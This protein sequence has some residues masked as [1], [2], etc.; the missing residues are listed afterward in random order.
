MLFGFVLLFGYAFIVWLVFFKFKWMKFNIAWGVVS[1]SVGLHLLIIFMLGLRFVAPYATE[2]K[3]IQHTIQLVPRLP[4][5][6]LV[7]EVLVAPN[8]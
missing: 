4:E 1:V 7:T 5:P 8:E 3:V 6:T 2:A